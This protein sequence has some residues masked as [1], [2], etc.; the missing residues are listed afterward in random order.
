[1]ATQ[2]AG[3]MLHSDAEWVQ[4]HLSHSVGGVVGYCRGSGAPMKNV[5]P[6]GKLF[7][8]SR[9]ASPKQVAFW[10]DFVDNPLVTVAQAWDQFGQEL[11]VGSREKWLALVE[12]LPAIRAKGELRVIRGENTFVP[13]SPV[14]LRDVGVQEVQ[15]AAKGWSVGPE[16][17]QRLIRHSVS[18]FAVDLEP[19]L[20]DRVQTTVVRVVRDTQLSDRVKRCHD[21]RCQICGQTVALADG[22]GYAEGHHVQPLGSP[23]NGPDVMENIICLCPNHHAACDFGAIR[24]SLSALRREDGHEVHPRYIDYHNQVVYRGTDRHAAPRALGD[25]K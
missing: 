15:H 16:D 4:F 5:R 14:L 21:Y 2:N 6:G 11:G 20:P 17:V 7:F 12:R 19:P 24:L 18:E 1:M 9:G 22:S 25:P 8:M 13:R 3:Y 23:H 10:A